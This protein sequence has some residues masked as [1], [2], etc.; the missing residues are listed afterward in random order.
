MLAD[1][2]TSAL[3]FPLSGDFLN[4]RLARFTAAGF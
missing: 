4:A 3:E 2:A 1:F